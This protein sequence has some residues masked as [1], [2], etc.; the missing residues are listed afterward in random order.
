MKLNLLWELKVNEL[1]VHFIAS[2]IIGAVMFLI[3]AG[4]DLIAGIHVH[5]ASGFGFWQF[6][7]CAFW[8]LFVVWSYLLA[9]KWGEKK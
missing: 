1:E 4:W 3:G 6:I 5:H 8:G 9:V 7:W 2:A